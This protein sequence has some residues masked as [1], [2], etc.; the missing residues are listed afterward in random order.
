MGSSRVFTRIGTNLQRLLLLRE[1]TC[2]EYILL[3]SSNIKNLRHVFAADKIH[4][5]KCAQLLDTW[6]LFYKGLCDIF[7]VEGREGHKVGGSV[8]ELLEP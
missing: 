6:R 8:K 1:W 3:F 2:K 5:F 7:V 4:Q